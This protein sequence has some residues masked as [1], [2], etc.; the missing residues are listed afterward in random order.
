MSSSKKSVAFFE[1]GS[2]YHRTKILQEDYTV[3][4]GK[5]GGF[6]TK[7]EA[8]ESYAKYN[9]EYEKQLEVHHLNIDKEVYFSNYLI[10]WY[11]NIF[12]D[13]EP[14]NTY[15]LGVAYIIYNL[16]VPFL[17][18]NDYSIDIKLR[19]INTTYLDSLLEELSKVTPSSGNKCQEVLSVALRDARDEQYIIGSPMEGTKKYKRNKPK[20]KIL[21]KEELKKLL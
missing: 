12:K 5:K 18:Q 19:L 14:E 13:R 15:A 7:E 9:N 20:I 6:K 10:Y 2:W 17:R 4:Y 16:I 8:E 11:E 1:R 21:K 3:T